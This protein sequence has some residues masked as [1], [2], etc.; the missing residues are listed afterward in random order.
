MRRNGGAMRRII[1]AGLLAGTALYEPDAFAGETQHTP[2]AVVDGTTTRLFVRGM[3][4]QLYEGSLTSEVF[5]GWSTIPGG[6]AT[7]SQPGVLLDSAGKLR[8]YVQGLDNRPWVNIKTNGSWAGE[9]RAEWW[10]TQ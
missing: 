8:L 5:S 2:V 3:D 9:R 6:G 1:I 10:E 4:G 7:P